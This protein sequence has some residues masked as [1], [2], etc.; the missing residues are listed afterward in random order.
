MI[1]ELRNFLCN[2]NR[3]HQPGENMD[4]KK[5]IGD[6]SVSIG[7]KVSGSAIVTGDHNVVKVSYQ[8][9]TLPEPSEV[10]IREELAALRSIL[11][12]LQASEA[13]R[14]RM[15]RALEDAATETELPEAEQD[16]DVIGGAMERAIQ[17][18]EKA[19]DFTEK[20]SK[21]TP[22]L[23]NAAAWLGKN[24]HNILAVVGLTV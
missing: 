14:R 9:T 8:K 11:L 15:E 24:W 23:K 1:G 17:Y 18:A 13:D 22:H 19:E 5:S 2:P 4:K 21:I 6:R 10:N 12:E 3:L 20:I 16:K 7:G